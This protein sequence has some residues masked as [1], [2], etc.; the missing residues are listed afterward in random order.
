M[1][2]N[3]SREKLIMKEYGRNVQNMVEEAVKIEDREERNKAVQ[4]IVELMGRMYP[5]LKNLRDFK[6]KLWD[7][8]VIMSDFKLDIDAPHELPT[9]E[10]FSKPPKKI[11]YTQSRFRQKYYGKNI[12][13][14]I[15]LAAE[16]EAGEERDLLVALI[17][18]QMKKSYALWNKDGV[19]DDIIFSDIRKISN[20]QIDIPEHIKLSEA[21]RLTNVKNNKTKKRKKK[22]KKR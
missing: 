19:T 1:D 14:M 8:L 13:K 7:H 3:S 17:G 4:H 16:M 10:T 15:R 12:Q 22:K 9:R 21:K 5:Y 20:E 18:N 6:H 2:Y 11:P